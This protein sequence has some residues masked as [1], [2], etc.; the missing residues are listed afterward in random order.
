[1]NGQLFE[2]KEF[3]VTQ[4]IDRESLIVGTDQEGRLL[5]HVTDASTVP[6]YSMF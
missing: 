5:L 3:P 2:D 6:I 4:D 1:M